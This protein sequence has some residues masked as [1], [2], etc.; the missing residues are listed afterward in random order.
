MDSP[1]GEFHADL[2]PLLGETVIRKRASSAF[3]NTGL[4]A[5]LQQ[6]GARQ[7]VV[8]GLQPAARRRLP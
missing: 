4:A 6:L 1:H 3:E 2:V 7:L 5:A 8:C